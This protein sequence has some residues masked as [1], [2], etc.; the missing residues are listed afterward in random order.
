MH[1]Y[2]KETIECFPLAKMDLQCDSWYEVVIILKIVN[3]QTDTLVQN[4][5]YVLL[6]IQKFSYNLSNLFT[7]LF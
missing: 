5:N 7:L 2:G 3:S 1:L 4:L 6:T